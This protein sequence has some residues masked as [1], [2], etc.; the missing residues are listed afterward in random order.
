[1]ARFLFVNR[2]YPPESG[3][4]G[5]LLWELTAELAAAGH[6]VTVMTLG[7]GEAPGPVGVTGEAIQSGPGAWAC[8]R[9]PLLRDVTCPGPSGPS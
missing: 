3:A 4:T 1:M 6:E 5:Q 2:V 9:L 8:Q 7:G